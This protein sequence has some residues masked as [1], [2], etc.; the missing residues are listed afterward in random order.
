MKRIYKQTN[1]A[2]QLGHMAWSA[3]IATS[4]AKS[5]PSKKLNNRIAVNKFIAH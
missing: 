2:E 5:D 3:L 1:T 4:I